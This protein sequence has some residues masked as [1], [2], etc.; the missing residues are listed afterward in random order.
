MQDRLQD[1]VVAAD[2]GGTLRKSFKNLPISSV[3]SIGMGFVGNTPFDV[4]ILEYQSCAAERAYT[5]NFSML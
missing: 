4:I 3:E 5:W 1:H 2:N